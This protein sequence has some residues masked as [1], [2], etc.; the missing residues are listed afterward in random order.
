MQSSYSAI[1]EQ[2]I[3]LLNELSPREYQTV[4]TPHFSGSI[5]AHMRHVIDHFLALQQGVIDGAVDY[6][7][8]HRHN[9]VEQFPQ[10][11]LEVLNRLKKWISS[12]DTQACEQPLSVTSEIDVQETRSVTCNSTLERELVFVSSHAI[13]H[14]A[15]IRIMC[16]MQ[17]KDIPALF[18]YA[19]ATVTHMTEKKNSA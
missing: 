16:S 18:G 3:D 2:A 14:Y 17:N 4:L 5:G 6:N 7:V 8:R 10:S 13:H 15:L 11:A 12:L 1:I 9:T 19:P